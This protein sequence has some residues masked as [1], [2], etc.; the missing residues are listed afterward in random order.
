MPERLTR[1]YDSPA[2]RSQAAGT[3][4][5]IVAATR[6]LFLSRGYAAT[7]MADVAAA[8]G[9][10]VQT[11][12]SAA[13]G[14]AG[15]A[16][17]AWDVTVVGDLEAVPLRLRPEM[18]ELMGEPDPAVILRLYARLSRQVYERLGPLARVL[19]AGAAG[20]GSLLQLIDTT[21]GER[22]TGTTALAAHLHTMGALRANL[23][24]ESA[25]QR[26]WA[27]NGGEVA[28]GLTLRCGWSLD[29]YEDWLAESMAHAVLR[30]P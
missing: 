2:R 14:K 10:S 9:V 15:L 27:L 4:Q 28:D 1:P 3:Q 29:E 25:G 13:G 24:P 30:T 5:R 17:R 11:V 23:T 8:A 22:L 20:D 16:K 19:R 18:Q 26:L 7:T 21:E 6:E 12:Y